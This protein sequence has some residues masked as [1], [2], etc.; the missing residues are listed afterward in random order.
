MATY[1]SPDIINLAPIAAHGERGSVQTARATVTCAAAPATTDTLNFFYLPANARV[2]GGYLSATDMDINGSPAL[3]LNI[4]DAGDADR[5]FAASNVGQTGA[6]ALAQIATGLDAKFTTKTLITGVAQ[7]NAA[8]GAA[9]S[10]TLC[11]LYT[12]ED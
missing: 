1:N 8:T 6:A 2:V 11:L 3:T 4:G 9:G 10:V 12:V 7:A 5:F